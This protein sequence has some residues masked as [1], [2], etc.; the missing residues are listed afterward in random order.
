MKKLA[1]ELNVDEVD[2][3]DTKGIL[4]YSSTESAIGLDLYDVMLKQNNFDLKKYLFVDKNPYSASP[5]LKS[6]QTNRLFKFIMVPSYETQIIYQV[7][8]S[9][10]SLLILLN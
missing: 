5:L 1:E 9:Y 10:E 8:L 7:G 6:A 4:S 2:F 3:S